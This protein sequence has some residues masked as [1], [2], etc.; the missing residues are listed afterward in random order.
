MTPQEINI[1]IAESVG[2]VFAEM[3]EP[4]GSKWNAWLDPNGEIRIDIPSYTVDLN[5]IHEIEESIL[6]AS[7]DWNYTLNLGD[8]VRPEIYDPKDCFWKSTTWTWRVVNANALQRCEA[9]LRTIGK[10]K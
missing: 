8:V 3:E 4:S 5:A 6:K 7:K 2:W 10:W 1:A 9:Y